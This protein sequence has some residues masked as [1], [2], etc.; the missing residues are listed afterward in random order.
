MYMFVCVYIHIYIYIYTY[1]YLYLSLYMCIYK[2][3]YTYTHVTLE[4][5]PV[6]QSDQDDR[7]DR[8]HEES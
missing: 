1:Q 2:C 3:I 8:V 6:R 4:G 5:A 7:R